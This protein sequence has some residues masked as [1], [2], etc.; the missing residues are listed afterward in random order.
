MYF[1]VVRKLKIKY[2]Y[3]ATVVAFGW[4]LTPPIGE[5]LVSTAEEIS[6]IQL[7][8]MRY[9]LAFIGLLILLVKERNSIKLLLKSLRVNWKKY[10][11]TAVL[12]ALMP[13]FLFFAVQWTTASSAS[14][15]LN[16]NIVFIPFFAFLLMKEKV[17]KLQAMGLFVTLIGLFLL[18]FEKEIT[19]GSFVFGEMTLFGNL[20]ALLSGVAWG[21]YTVFLK[22]FFSTDDP[23]HVTAINLFLGALLLTLPAGIVESFNMHLSLL[24]VGLLIVVAFV[25]TSL[26]FTYW[27]EL[28]GV[29]S[30]T[31]TGIIQALVPVISTV[32]AIIW[33]TE[34][35][36]YLFV[37]GA[38]L[39]ACGIFF[40][41][42]EIDVSISRKQNLKEKEK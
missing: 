11:V 33:L 28:L 26:A 13:V 29:L 32:I 14:F 9:L 20:L 18:I 38:M 34:T 22:K 24:G 7:A 41:E 37:I 8:L 3:Y 4:A 30:A 21:F 16:A 17:R 40:V 19:S 2:W 23:M 35:I 12:S 42:K 31:K 1:A 5:F 36:T 10:I 39:I 27:L 25:S 15:L 6:P